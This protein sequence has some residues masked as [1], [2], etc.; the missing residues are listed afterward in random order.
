MCLTAAARRFLCPTKGAVPHERFKNEKAAQ[1][2]VSV[3]SQPDLHFLFTIV[4]GIFVGNGIGSAAL[5]AVNIVLSYI[6]VLSALYMLTSVG[7]ANATA[8]RFGRVDKK[9]A[10]LAF[11]HSFA[12]CSSPLYSRW[13]APA[14][15]GRSAIFLARMKPRSITPPTAFSGIPFLSF[16]PCFRFQCSFSA[17]MTVRRC[18]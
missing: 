3:C 4:D 17:A 2:G 14:L 7:G 15:R 9:G 11:M 5:G 1:A 8:I 16:L 12:C 10:N 6:L 13:Q 18:S